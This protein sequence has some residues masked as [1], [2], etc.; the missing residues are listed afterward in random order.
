LYEQNKNNR[1]S[2]NAS[3]ETFK[4]TNRKDDFDR[5]TRTSP[6]SANTPTQCQPT[7]DTSKI[8][9]SSPAIIVAD[10]HMHF[11]RRLPQTEMI[12]NGRLSATQLDR[13]T[14]ILKDKPVKKGLL[15]P[16]SYSR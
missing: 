11:L 1:Q 16:K 13:L 14:G 8:L 3:R 7:N 10:E 9:T 5:W 2:P 15:L 4:W 12:I 6:L